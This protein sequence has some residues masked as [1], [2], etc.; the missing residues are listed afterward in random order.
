MSSEWK[1]SVLVR[2]NRKERKF[3]SSSTDEERMESSD[4]VLVE[5]GRV[6]EKERVRTL[7]HYIQAV[8]ELD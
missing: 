7:E 5:S 4:G 8:Y 2:G 3:L 6:E 1:Q